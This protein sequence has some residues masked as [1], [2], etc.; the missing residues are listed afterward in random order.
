MQTSLYLESNMFP[1]MQRVSEEVDMTTSQN[2]ISLNLS[3]SQLALYAEDEI[4][5][6]KLI[7]L[8]QTCRRY[9]YLAR[10]AREIYDT[11]CSY[12]NGL[13]LLLNKLHQPAKS[14]LS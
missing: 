13:E 6:K 3:Q 8:Q 12:L 9:L 11:E 2:C 5:L 4:F 14:L 7:L 10:K 1:T